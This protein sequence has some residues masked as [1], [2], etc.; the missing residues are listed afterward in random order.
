MTTQYENVKKRRP[1]KAKRLSPFFMFF[2]VSLSYP[3]EIL[4][5]ALFIMTKQ[6]GKVRNMGTQGANRPMGV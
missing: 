5:T 3:A 6:F 4:H 1:R 2:H